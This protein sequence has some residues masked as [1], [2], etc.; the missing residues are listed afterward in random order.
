ML[1]MGPQQ[2]RLQGPLPQQ[3]LARLRVV[4]GPAS[5][6]RLRRQAEGLGTPQGQGQGRGQ[7]TDPTLPGGYGRQ[8]HRATTRRGRGY[9]PYS[10]TFGG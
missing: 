8:S 2:G 4:P 9:R 1:G 7:V 3:S 5:Q 6:H 10:T